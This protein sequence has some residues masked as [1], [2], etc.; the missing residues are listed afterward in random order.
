MRVPALARQMQITR[1]L[2]ER[3]AQLNQLLNRG[4]RLLDHE[5][6]RLAPV[7]PCTRDHRIAHMI[8]ERVARIENG[9]N[10]ALRPC[11]GAAV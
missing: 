3:H 11:G 6:N 1:I 9:G 10:P 8:F 2:I 7:Q 4:G 5:F